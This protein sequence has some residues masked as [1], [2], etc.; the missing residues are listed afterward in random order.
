MAHQKTLEH[1]LES[2]P[3]GVV[4]HDRERRIIYLNRAA[5][6]ITG[7][8]R[9][10]LLGKDCH[11]AFGAPFCGQHCSFF[12]G[13]QLVGLSKTILSISLPNRGYP[14]KLLCR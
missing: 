3:E 11:E 8:P 6:E 14:N 13:R 1:I 7:W 12:E 4:G 10:E 2:I 5:E 9:D